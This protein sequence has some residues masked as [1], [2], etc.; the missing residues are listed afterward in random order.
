MNPFKR[1]SG[2][3]IRK[4]LALLGVAAIVVFLLFACADVQGLSEPSLSDQV[5]LFSRDLKGIASQV[6]DAIGDSNHQLFIV[7]EYPDDPGRQSRLAATRETLARNI[8]SVLRK[9]DAMQGP[10]IM[11]QLREK[12]RSQVEKLYAQQ[13]LIISAVDRD[14]EEA[15]KSAIKQSTDIWDDMVDVG[16]QMDDVAQ[17]LALE[18]NAILV[19]RTSGYKSL[20]QNGIWN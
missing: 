20:P 18:S 6:K 2:S 13:Q 5:T 19:P 14:D 7:R 8:D 11:D 12:Y 16:A 17:D 10:S 4:P 9:T 3:P 1:L 15:L